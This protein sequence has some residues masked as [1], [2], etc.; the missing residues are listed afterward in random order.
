VTGAPRGL[1][2]AIGFAATLAGASCVGALGL[3]E[4]Q[5]DAV[6]RLCQC[7]DSQALHGSKSACV[8]SVGHRLEIATEQTRAQW[9]TNFAKNCGT[10]TNA[11]EC[12]GHAPTCQAITE[13][14][15]STGTGLECCTGNCAE[16][17]CA[18][19]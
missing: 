11:L 16:G 10:C 8:A 19:N 15:L 18:A 1:A 12:L 7:P 3:D 14:C 5:T 4:K 6:E 2:V 17:K 9:M 13:P